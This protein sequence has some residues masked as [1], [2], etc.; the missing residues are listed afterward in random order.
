MI[1]VVIP[2]I[3]TFKLTEAAAASTAACDVQPAIARPRIST[4]S[5]AVVI[6]GVK[7]R[8]FFASRGLL[9]HRRLQS[10]VACTL[11]LALFSFFAALLLLQTVNPFY[12]TTSTVVSCRSVRVV[13]NAVFALRLRWRDASPAHSNTQNSTARAFCAFSA[14]SHL[15]L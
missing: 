4:T 2:C 8:H 13:Q 6:F 15:L 1:G 14:F 11:R 12:V 5:S 7:T 9:R 3:S 10:C